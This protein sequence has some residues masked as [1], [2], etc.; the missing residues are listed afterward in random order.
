[1]AVRLSQAFANVATNALPAYPNPHGNSHANMSGD[2]TRDTDPPYFSITAQPRHPVHQNWDALGTA[3]VANIPGIAAAA[4]ALNRELI[5][6]NEPATYHNSEG[7][8]VRSAA[9]YLLHPVNQVLSSHAGALMRCQSEATANRVRSD[10]TYYRGPNAQNPAF[11]AFAVV[12]FKKRGVIKQTEFAA[13]IR[14]RVQPSAAQVQATI[15]AALATANETYFG[16]DA[17]VLIKQAASYA[18]AHRTPFVALFD[19]DFLVLVH[20]TQMAITADI[21]DVGSHCELDIIPNAQ[22]QRMRAALLGF[23]ADAYNNAPIV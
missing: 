2:S 19:W 9:Q 5:Y 8:V 1:M 22:S 6:L 23:L 10:I 7:D 12:E 21:T 3:A 11:K 20:F 15:T 18:I 16:G 13:T 17:L 14:H 4:H